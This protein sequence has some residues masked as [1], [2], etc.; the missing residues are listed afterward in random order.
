MKHKV[1]I[2]ILLIIFI[3][4]STSVFAI[5]YEKY[6]EFPLKAELKVCTPD[7]VWKIEFREAVENEQTLKDNIFIIDTDTGFPFSTDI[8]LDKD[9]RTVFVN[10]KYPFQKGGNYTL[11]INM[12]IKTADNKD[13]LDNSY[14]VPFEIATGDLL[15]EMQQFYGTKKEELLR[16]KDELG[17]W[18]RVENR[19]LSDRLKKMEDELSQDNKNRML[20]YNN[21]ATAF[22]LS[23]ITNINIDKLLS[24]RTSS[25]DYYKLGDKTV[26]FRGR[27]WDVALIKQKVDTTNILLRLGMQNDHINF[28]ESRGLSRT[29]VCMLAR[30]MQLLGFNYRSL[31]YGVDDPK[32]ISDAVK[33]LAESI[34]AQL[35]KYESTM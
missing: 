4:G 26:D 21:Y 10:H 16:L 20:I 6:R 1:T 29:T 27:Y 24:S 5:S 9:G 17:N 12:T 31:S 19:L 3:F 18:C 15:D 32:K 33:G 2:I 30:D 28:L 23:A 25:P 13:F 7:K 35:K 22:Y 11:Y 8:K 34:E 14:K